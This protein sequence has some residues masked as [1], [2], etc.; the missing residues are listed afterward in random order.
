LLAQTNDPN[1]IAINKMLKQSAEELTSY[2]Y[3]RSIELA[4]TSLSES[5]KID[6]TDGVIESLMILS[7][8]HKSK[9]DYSSGLNYYLQALS[10]IEKE[11]DQQKLYRVNY[12]IGQLFFDWGVPEKALIYF[13]NANNIGGE[14]LS[15]DER[16]TLSLTTAETHLKLKDSDQALSQYEKVLAIHQRNKNQQ[17]TI[18]TLKSIASIY[19]RLDDHDNSLKYNFQILEINEALSD[20]INTAISLNAIGFIYKGV[21]D[22]ENALSYFNGA[23][24]LNRQLNK[25]GVNDNEIVSNLINIGVIYQALGDYRSS[26]KIFNDALEIKEKSGSVIEVAVMQNYLASIYLSLSNYSKAKEHTTKAIDLLEHTEYKRML[27]ENYK[28]LSEINERLGNHESALVSYKEYS[29]IQDS[30]LYH[31]QGVRD[32]ERYKQFVVET[33]EKE[34]KLSIIDREMREL[35]SRAE[36]VKFEKERQDIELL[37]RKRELQN[38]SLKN[39][40]LEQE[41][42]VQE[43]LLQQEQIETSIKSQEIIVLEQKRDLQN[44][45][46]QNS[47]LR[48]NER[49][50]EIQLQSSQLELQQ[51][52]LEKGN[53]RQR[54][55]IGASVFLVIILL[56]ILIGYAIKRRDNKKLQNQFSEINEQKQQIEGINIELLDLNEEKNNLIGIVAHDLK[57]PLNQISG[58]LSIIK[59][60]ATDQ[61]EEQKE[62]ITKIDES[63]Q[64]LRNMVTKILDVSAIES[65]SLNISFEEVDLKK[66]LK[67]AIG[68]FD[69]RAAKKSIAIKQK[70]TE[71]TTTILADPSYVSEVFENLMSNAVKYSPLEK[72]V[73]V[74]LSQQWDKVRV[75]F[76]DQGQGINKKDMTKLFRMYQKLTA[77]PTSGED[78]TG[79][80]LSIVKKYVEAVNGKVWCESEEGNGSTFIVEFDSYQR[81]HS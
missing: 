76:I 17:L 69:E 28:R 61:D 36:K 80:G 71:D 65:K 21:E 8:A 14:L 67:D 24:E 25:N 40:Q 30:V 58:I 41:R 27:A 48:E 18:N 75:E 10:E 50:K 43:L 23:L 72:T 81:T 45:E 9:R 78:S 19:N 44:T 79:L 64:R 6:Y 63:T 47:Q 66:V 16:I 49:Q 26:I 20:S 52:Q 15:E 77:S 62:Y 39:D 12:K 55:F 57:S 73:I 7:E 2:K 37:L 35:E 54:Y 70:I 31:E 46:I 33:T 74:R 4:T 29:L 68:R 56:L 22:L 53:V 38:S 3:D 1:R 32:R 60:T 11:K 59:L 5:N 51:L 42:K 34:S 13:D